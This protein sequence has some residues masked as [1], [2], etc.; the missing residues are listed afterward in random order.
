M[1]I[2]VTTVVTNSNNIT[3]YTIKSNTNDADNTVGNET[4][5]GM[6][7]SQQYDTS[8]N[9]STDEYVYEIVYLDNCQFIS[10]DMTIIHIC[11]CGDLFVFKLEDLRKG[12]LSIT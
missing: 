6:I 2:T 1:S 3:S 5:N 12:K 7:L 11:T 8:N 10:E 9:L 4:N